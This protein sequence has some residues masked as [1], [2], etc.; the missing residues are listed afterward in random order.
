VATLAEGATNAASARARKTRRTSM[1]WFFPA[2]VSYAFADVRD[3]TVLCAQSL[4]SSTT[5]SPSGG[6]STEAIP[7]RA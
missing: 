4:K 7:T 2:P 5:I 6:S 1:G 3:R